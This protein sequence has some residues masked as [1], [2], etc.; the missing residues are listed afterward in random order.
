MRAHFF[1]RRFSLHLFDL[2]VYLF[3]FEVMWFIWRISRT[4][5][6][7]KFE[8]CEVQRRFRKRRNL[9]NNQIRPTDSWSF[10]GNELYSNTSGCI[11]IIIFRGTIKSNDFDISFASKCKSKL[12]DLISVSALNQVK[13][14]ENCHVKSE[15][16]TLRAI[17]TTITLKKIVDMLKIQILTKTN[18]IRINLIRKFSSTLFLNF[19]KISLTHSVQSYSL[20]VKLFKTYQID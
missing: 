8:I 20:M 2:V 6:A 1:T 11:D 4:I 16:R 19:H 12:A 10:N 9:C 14:C 15:S 17:T 18:K 7:S 5:I 3:T 13:F